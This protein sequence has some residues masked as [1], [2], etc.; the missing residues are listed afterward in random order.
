MSRGQSTEAFNA[1]MAAQKQQQAQAG[2]ALDSAN[3]G[4]DDYR[5][6]VHKFIESNPYGEGGP[7]QRDTNTRIGTVADASQNALAGQLA[8]QKQRTGENSAGVATTMAES[9]RRGS[10]EAMDAM[11]QADADR[12]SKDT[13]Y[14]AE[15]AQLLQFSPEV[16]ARIYGTATGGQASSLGTATE[17]AKTKSFWEQFGS[18][19]VRGAAAGAAGATTGC[20]IA[21]AIY[22]VDDPRTHLTRAWLNLEFRKSVLGAAVM[23]F[24]LAF[25]QRIAGVVRNNRLVRLAL[26]PIFVLALNRARAW[27][28]DEVSHA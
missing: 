12:A 19:L 28:A 25:G 27:K 3:Q 10:R 21:E 26:T 16:N 18:D 7:Y 13:A 23:K 20:W 4:L 22:G 11:A 2:A 15:G 24:Y 8:D 9:K 5:Q 14:K 6:N 1:S 17:A